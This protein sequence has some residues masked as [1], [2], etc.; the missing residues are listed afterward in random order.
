MYGVFIQCISVYVYLRS[1]STPFYAAVQVVKKAFK[2]LQSLTSHV[3][4]NHEGFIGFLPKCLSKDTRYV[5]CV[6][7]M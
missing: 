3:A 1:A 2:L 6:W 7:R 4:L 5:Q